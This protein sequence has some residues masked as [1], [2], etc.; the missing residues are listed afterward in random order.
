VKFRRLKIKCIK[1]AGAAYQWARFWLNWHSGKYSAKHITVDGDVRSAGRNVCV[2]SIYSLD[3]PILP[4]VVDLIAAIKRAGYTLVV[5]VNGRKVA[6][7]WFEGQI[8]DNDIV[9]ARPN[10][11]RDFAAYQLATNLLL[12]ANTAVERLLYCNDSVF[13]LDKN[14]SKDIFGTLISADEP[15]IGMTET[16]EVHYHVS[17]WCFQMSHEALN[18]TAFVN[19]W[20][21]YRPIDSRKHAICRGEV[22]LSRVMLRAQFIPNV[23]FSADSLLRALLERHKDP[24]ANSCSPSS[25]HAV[26]RLFFAGEKMNQTHWLGSFLISTLGF[27]FLKKDVA[28]RRVYPMSVTL[29]TL[30]ELTSNCE[31]KQREVRLKGTRSNLSATQK[32]LYDAGL[33]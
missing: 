13:Y 24:D 27:P 26:L 9:I 21:R 5:I 28:F 11:G 20:R 25:L 7:E 30:S 3:G 8:G 14:D 33:I 12:D 1:R 4:S 19:F 15:W 23:L 10:L 2:F 29:A 32:L 16:H 22:E 17:S 18:S 6:R 31:D